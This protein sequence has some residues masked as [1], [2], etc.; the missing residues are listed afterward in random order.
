MSA[1]V[2]V[3]V[4]RDAV[5]ER[6]ANPSLH[7]ASRLTVAALGVL[8]FA[9]GLQS[10]EPSLQDLSASLKV[11]LLENLPAT[12]HESDHD[13]NHQESAPRLRNFRWV[14]EPKNDGHWWKVKVSSGN[15]RN[16][17]QIQ[18]RDLRPLDRDRQVFHVA[19]VLPTQIDFEQQVWES[20][21][22]LYSGSTKA[23]M[24]V[25]IDLDIENTIRLDTGKSIVPDVIFRLKVVQS[26]IR[27]DNMVVEHMAGVGGSAAR[28]LGEG[29]RSSLKQ[30][31][32]SLERNLLA[33]ANAAV[34]KA[35]DTR[36]VR[37]SLTKLLG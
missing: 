1:K 32:P 28:L 22:R 10:N 24:R 15:L 30:W 26:N 12:L 4:S 34:L 33:R 31:K 19:L 17:L 6:G 27:Y 9:M 18:V 29:V 14:R 20:G 7:S 16:D 23:R 13:W 3:T 37:L 36:E 25:L 8:I 35:G 2:K 11:L 5:S 21:L